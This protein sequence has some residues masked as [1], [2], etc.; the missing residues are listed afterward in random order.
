MSESDER[1]RA[2]EARRAA[3][4]TGNDEGEEQPRSRRGDDA[5]AAEPAFE[6][7]NRAA[8][9][10][11]QR[12][13]EEEQERQRERERREEEQRRR[14]QEARDR[15][16]AERRR[17]EEEAQ[18]ERQRKNEEKKQKEQEEA[19]K[20]RKPGQKRK[21]LG[22]LSPEKKKLLKQLIMQKAAEEMRAEAKRRQ[23]EK[24]NHLKT[25]VGPLNVD[26]LDQGALEARV[27]ELHKRVNQLEEEKYDWEEKLLKQDAEMNELTIKVNDVKGKFV[28]PVLKKVSKTESK[29]ARFEK[30]KDTGSI[31]AFRGQLKST[32]QNKYALEEKEEGH[33]TQDWREHLKNTKEEDGAPVE[34]GVPEGIA[35]E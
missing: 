35:A 32:G 18:M 30:M 34:N 23:E 27:K 13:Q 15:E 9:E 22:G 19:A 2:R 17:R 16:D 24:E 7:D 10:E 29:L 20:K 4:M 11:E 26:G 33:K 6:V 14:D 5:P 31:A 8:E 3:R 25:V 12:R 21:G 1:R 28:K